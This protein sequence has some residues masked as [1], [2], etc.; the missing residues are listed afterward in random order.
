MHI[1]QIRSMMLLHP[2]DYIS[3]DDALTS[4]AAAFA[5]SSEGDEGGS[6]G[7]RGEYGSKF[8]Y[9]CISSCYPG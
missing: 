1:S 8:F 2:E 4:K 9:L 5:S 6:G 3:G 7:L